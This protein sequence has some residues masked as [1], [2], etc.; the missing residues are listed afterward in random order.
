M[1]RTTRSF[2]SP[3]AS[4]FK[5]PGSKTEKKKRENPLR[6]EIAGKLQSAA[7]THSTKKVIFIANFGFEAWPLTSWYFR[8]LSFF[9]LMGHNIVLDKFTKNSSEQL[10]PNIRI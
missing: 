4:F 7:E 9:S 2:Y 5:T 10:P 3:A 1:S 6:L 8:S